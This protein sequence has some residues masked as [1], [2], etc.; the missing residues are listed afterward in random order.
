MY[1]SS[2][3]AHRGIVHTPLR[4]PGGKTRLAGF[5]QRVIEQGG[6]RG[7]TYVEPYAGGAGAALS[8]LHG[9]TVSHIRIND[10]DPC[11][12]AF[13]SA[14]TQHSAQLLTKVEQTPLTVEEWRRQRAIYQERDTSD[15]VKL[16]FATFY[17]NRTNRSGIMNAGVIGGQA[18][19]SRYKMNARYNKAG[20]RSRLEWIG[21][22]ADRITVT[23]RDG[24]ELLEEVVAAE[25]VFCYIDPPYFDKGSYLYMNSLTRDS[26]ARLADVLR[27][28]RTSLW[29]LTYDDVAEIRK[30]YRGL[31]QGTFSLPYSAHAVS[32]ATERMV[33]SDPVAALDT[34][35]G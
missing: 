7:C 10:L 14:A 31:Y 25:G 22:S 24:V 27:R 32:L 6:W 13:W 11:L 19:A 30:L 23:D 18:Q 34:V 17:L 26:H 15:P 1:L 2:V 4:Y 20:L 35:F 3:K 33:L 8:L 28:A 9:N 12:N 29:V 16:G 21:S 5:L